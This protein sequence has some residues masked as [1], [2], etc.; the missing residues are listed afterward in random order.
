MYLSLIYS[1][2]LV[3]KISKDVKEVPCKYSY[4][5]KLELFFI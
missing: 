2:S 5:I 4:N 3:Y 1:K